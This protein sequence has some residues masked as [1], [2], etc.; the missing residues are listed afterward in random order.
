MKLSLTALLLA[1]FASLGLVTPVVL[2]QDKE[3]EDPTPSFKKRL[4]SEKEFITKV[5]EA[6]VKAVRTAPA[7]L[8]LDTYKITDPKPN[9]KVIEII[10]NWAGSLTGKK[11][12]STIKI[13]V[14]PTDKDKWEVI[15]IEYTDDNPSLKVGMEKN[16]KNLKAKFNR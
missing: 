11:F 9:R 4:D 12:K 7:K 3:K 16:L 14:D 15:D 6:T 2:A 13:T 1:A 8:E 5:G 10:M